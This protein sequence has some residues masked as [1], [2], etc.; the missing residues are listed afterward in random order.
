MVSWKLF[1]V[2]E[3]FFVACTISPATLYAIPEIRI[4]ILKSG[5]FRVIMP[6]IPGTG[7]FVFH[8]NVN[9][10]IPPQSQGDLNK[11]TKSS[12]NGVWILEFPTTKL[13][14]GDF[15]SYWVFV[16]HNHL[17][18][19][20]DRQVWT[21]TELLDSYPPL[22]TRCV[23]ASTVVNG[24][25]ST[26]VGQVIID[27]AFTGAEI[28]QNTW[29]PE[30]FIP[31]YSAPNY[32]FNSYQ[33]I[34]ETLF[35]L[36]GVLHLKPLALESEDAVRGE[37][38][39]RNGCTSSKPTKCFYI[40]GSS[41]LLPPVKSARIT[42]QSS[43]KY[44]KIEIRAKL[45]QGDWIFPIIQ[46]E[47]KNDETENSPKVWVAYSRGNQHLRGNSGE[48]IGATILFAGPVLTPSEPGRS[49]E[50]ISQRSPNPYN[51]DFHVFSLIWA[52][53]KMTFSID[54]HEIGT[55]D[56][57]KNFADPA[58][59]IGSTWTSPE[60]PFDKEY[61]ISLGVG[62]GG[63]ADFPDGYTSGNNQKPWVNGERNQVKK[64]FNTR[65]VWGGTWN[66]N[67]A[68]LQIDYVKVT[69]L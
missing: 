55:V 12:Q 60:T 68:A 7:L 33:N 45:P 34:Q 58:H 4:E 41:F 16:T 18:F 38:N 37:L 66:G 26:C 54:S 31:T 9:E 46:L 35:N 23:T 61:V 13:K 25:T 40:Q 17:G 2:L 48:D 36:N 39:L 24:G 8:G 19:R 10:D 59:G 1:L 64:F 56:L 67:K 11:E 21:V 65:N 14:A 62:V 63:I 27:D 50:L 15:I 69:A 28:D 51:A 44:G 57:K 47:P 43:F 20:K 30:H 32:E 53:G 3:L 5:G 52:P 22:K 49:K 6:D 29:V 42:S